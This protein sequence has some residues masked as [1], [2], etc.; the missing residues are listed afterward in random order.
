MRLVGSA[1]P[2]YDSASG[3]QSF[4]SQSSVGDW[5]GARHHGT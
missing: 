1:T 4:K 3:T 5:R 2:T